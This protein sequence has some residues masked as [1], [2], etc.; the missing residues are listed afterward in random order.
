[1]FPIHNKM[2]FSFTDIIFALKPFAEMII[3]AMTVLG[4]HYYWRSQYE[5]R[6]NLEH[7][8]G[9]ERP[10]IL[11][12]I[13]L[14]TMIALAAQVV[15]SFVFRPA[16]T[17]SSNLDRDTDIGSVIILV[18]VYVHFHFQF[19]MERKLRKF[20]ASPR[21]NIKMN[22]MGLAWVF[23]GMA[24]VGAFAKTLGEVFSLGA[25]ELA[26]S[27]AMA[28]WS[29]VAGTLIGVLGGLYALGLLTPVFMR[30]LYPCSRIEGPTRDL[31]EACF[32]KA[33]LKAPAL[34]AINLEQF[35][36]HN[37]MVVGMAT[38]RGVLS[39]C[40]F[41]TQSLVTQLEPSELEAVLLHEVS[42]IK[43]E[44]ILKRILFSGATVLVIVGV[45]ALS[46]MAM[47]ALFFVSPQA[48]NAKTL[49]LISVF[50]VL[51]AFVASQYLARRQ[52]Y[53]QEIEADA[54]AVFI[55]GANLDALA[56]AL[57]KIDVL[58]DQ[59]SDKKDPQS[60]LCVGCA[61]PTTEQRIKLLRERAERDGHGKLAA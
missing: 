57:R 27:S 53:K 43:L 8:P 25:K 29:F 37:A 18:A 56:T 14:V 11:Y 35:N 1:M 58:N 42:H 47:V 55:L 60:Y 23:A 10:K 26:V 15:S 3:A 52:V 36:S 44:H 16:S 50:S 45:L 41:L 39:Q 22:L 7:I 38:G 54:H 5:E 34:W 31:I 13:R 51:A 32:K 17:P 40:L 59:M 19:V 12:K 33:G 24:V 46:V 20:A 61:H 21:Q 6:V 48:V 2:S 49:S 9:Y 4:A 30:Q 28:Q